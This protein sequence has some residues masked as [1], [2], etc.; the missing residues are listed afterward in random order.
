MDSACAEHTQCTEAKGAFARVPNSPPPSTT[1]AHLTCD[2]S[3]Y[4][5]ALQRLRHRFGAGSRTRARCAVL[6]RAS[7]HRSTLTHS[8]QAVGRQDQGAVCCGFGCTQLRCAILAILPLRG[9]LLASAR[10][11][12]ALTQGAC[13]TGQPTALRREHQRSTSPGKFSA[14]PRE[15]ASSQPFMHAGHSCGSAVRD[16]FTAQVRRITPASLFV[17]QRINNLARRRSAEL[18]ATTR[19]PRRR[20]PLRQELAR[21]VLN[22]QVR[23]KLIVS[24]DMRVCPNQQQHRNHHNNHKYRLSFLRRCSAAASSGRPRIMRSLSALH[25]RGKRFRCPFQTESCTGPS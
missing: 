8:T 20:S 10:S 12:R 9:P 24:L 21:A 22:L 19:G 11:A 5:Q 3:R 17:T 4:A 6:P 7:P 18:T 13:R 14:I 23:E 15:L 16:A 25:T 1:T 2:T